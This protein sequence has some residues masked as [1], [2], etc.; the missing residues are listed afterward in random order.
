M[1]IKTRVLGM[2]CAAGLASAAVAQVPA[3]FDHVAV[4]TPIVIGIHN[5]EKFTGSAQQWASSIAPPEAMGGFQ[6]AEMML[7][8]PGLNAGGSA[9]IA[10][11]LDPDMGEPIP[12]IILPVSDYNAF[13]EA[14]QGQPGNGVTAIN[15]M[16]G[17]AFVKPVGDG[18]VAMGQS[19]DTVSAFDAAAGK[20][21]SHDERLGKIA[22]EAAGGT[23]IFVV[24]DVPAMRPYLE[25]GMVEMQQNMEMMAMM[26]GDAVGAQIA[27]M[28]GAMEAVVRDGRTAFMGMGTGE[29]GIWLDFAGQFTEGS[30]TAGYFAD[31]GDSATLFS[32][33]PQMEYIAAWSID[34]SN[35]GLRK[36]ME[37]MAEMNG[38]GGFGFDVSALKAATGSAAVM[39]KT[40]GLF[41]GGLFANTVTFARA[42]DGQTLLG[43]W[44]NMITSTDGTSQEGILMKA[45]VE[46]N[47]TEVAGRP[48]HAWGV[49]MEADPN[50]E[51]AMMASMAIQQMAMMFGGEAGVRG[52][53]AAGEDGVYTTMSRNSALL[54]KALTNSGSSF[55]DEP[56][57]KAVAANLP[58]NRSMEGYLNI[59]GVLDMFAPM[60]A[61]LGAPAISDVPEDMLPIGMS[62][63]TGEGG[64]HSRVYVPGSVIE[65]VSSM[66][67]EMNGGGVDQEPADKPRF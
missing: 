26:G 55:A 7:G 61:M 60:M 18:F 31:G 4:D 29:K 39:G 38:G 57:V 54:E 30:D 56:G 45:S 66:A 9:A 8:T 2:L 62:L 33:L 65:F 35:D 16:G 42:D 49:T 53:A 41:A 17:E 47:A 63:S 14:M 5:L 13:V 34:N 25:M 6:M 23:D 27:A 3:S 50:H 51:N 58:D 24:I 52:Y 22:A 10:M 21:K 11:T 19:F 1:N 37:G 12:V 40:P 48:V 43:Q 36:L 20:R 32:H 64:M 46:D 28:T 59:K 15:M 44:K 67:A